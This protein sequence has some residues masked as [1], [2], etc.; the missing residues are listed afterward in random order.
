[1]WKEAEE[2]GKGRN[3][4]KE[5]GDKKEEGRGIGRRRC[6]DS[7]R[8]LREPFNAGGRGSR[9]GVYSV[10]CDREG[11]AVIML[12]GACARNDVMFSA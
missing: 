7:V 1:M 2:E 4:P 10:R 8:L 12:P 3:E 5:D 11:M 6:N 9:R